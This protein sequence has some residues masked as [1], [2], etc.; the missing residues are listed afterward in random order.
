MGDFRLPGTIIQE[1]GHES[2]F[3]ETS[4]ENWRVD[5]PT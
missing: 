4:G 5:N 2:L 3:Q 1:M